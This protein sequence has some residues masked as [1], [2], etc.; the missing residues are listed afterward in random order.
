GWLAAGGF[1]AGEGA[2]TWTAGDDLPKNTQVTIDFLGLTASNDAGL[3]AGTVTAI[4]GTFLL[5]TNGDQILA[6]QGVAPT[7]GDTSNFVTA[8]QMNAAWD[9]DATSDSTSAQPSVFTDGVNSISITPEFDNAFYNCDT[10]DGTPAELRAAITDSSHWTRSNT[11]LTPPGCM[12]TPVE[13]QS[14]SVD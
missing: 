4:S 14:F 13:L 9:S 10:V 12:H 7:A 1:R 6:Y 3:P 2:I 8:I 5:S 11:R